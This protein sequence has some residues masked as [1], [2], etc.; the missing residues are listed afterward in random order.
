M[1]KK[2]KWINKE[3]RSEKRM[4]GMHQYNV[5]DSLCRQAFICIQVHTYPSPI[6]SQSTPLTFMIPSDTRT[7]MP[8]NNA[9]QFT[10]IN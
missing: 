6:S 2:I 3:E 4:F 10:P 5:T 8:C 9:N 7:C 1:Q